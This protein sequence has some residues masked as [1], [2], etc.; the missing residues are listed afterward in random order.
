[1]KNIC[2]CILAYNEQKHIADTI[3]AI[4]DGNSAIDFDIVVYANGCTDRTVEI[5]KSLCY[6]IPNLKI[7]EL[8]KASKTLAWNT[9]FHENIYPILIFADGDIEPESGSVKAVSKFLKTNSNASLVNCE[10]WPK[11]EGLSI[12]Q[13]IVG[14]LQI[15]LSQTFLTGGF[16]AIRRADFEKTFCSTDIDGIP[17]DIVGEDLFIERIIDKNKFFI[18]NKKCFYEPPSFADYCK[19]LARLRLQNEQLSD[20]YS[21]I[22]DNHSGLQQNIFT[23]I[24]NKLTKGKNN[25]H[26]ILGLFSNLLKI[27]FKLI[28]QKKINAHYYELCHLKCGSDLILSKATRS[29]S[30][31]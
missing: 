15:P 18:L 11:K 31:K 12:S 10:L 6:S 4:L 7:R 29:N 14:L 9:A 16:Y 27:L 19:Y 1:M 24:K 13:R 2:V 23:R 17:S 8:E 25:R 28:F 30:S 5:V 26:L 21:N 22:F 3:Y 20:E